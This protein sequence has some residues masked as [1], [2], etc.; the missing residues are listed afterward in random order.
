MTSTR[1]LAAVAW[2][3]CAVSSVACAVSSVACNNA[4][5]GISEEN[6]GIAEQALMVDCGVLPMPDASIEYDRELIIRDVDVVE[7]PCRTT[8]TKGI[9]CGATQGKWTFGWMMAAMAGTSD[10]NSKGAK[11]FT[12]NWLKNWLSPQQPNVDAPVIA[13][14]P[15]IKQVL[16]D[17]WLTASG[18]PAGATLDTCLPDLRQA[19]FRLLAFVN[20]IDLD[21]GGSI[22]ANGGEFRVVFG[23]IGYDTFLETPDSPLQATVILEYKLPSTKPTM[24]WA[25]QLHGLSSYDVSTSIYRSK[26]QT[27]TDQIVNPGVEIGK[28]NGGSAIGQIRTNELSFDCNKGT[29]PSQLCDGLPPDMFA[30]TVW[31]MRQFK[32]PCTSGSCDLVQTSVTNTPDTSTNNTSLVNEFVIGQQWVILD[33]DHSIPASMEG[34]ASQSP[35][36]NEAVIWG[37]PNPLTALTAASMTPTQRAQSRHQF[38]FATCNGCHYRETQNQLDLFHIAPRAMGEA[39]MVSKFL[40]PD[41]Q[42]PS[43]PLASSDGA[44]AVNVHRVT[45]ATASTLKWEYNEPWRRACEIRRILS[46]GTT[47]FTKPTGHLN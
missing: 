22:Y 29:D 9:N 28:P 38:G 5:D 16:I 3:A 33:G 46:G 6:V 17:P 4:D 47:P 30:P 42:E 26:L 41:A 7:D 24:S 32:L 37:K 10:V 2:V 1:T 43:D 13:P 19:P 15:T 12:A 14:R 27:I 20:R 25:T 39:S 44:S 8:W 36:E 45:E 18:C 31:E 40:R 23:A 35:G 11:Q 34:N 21:G